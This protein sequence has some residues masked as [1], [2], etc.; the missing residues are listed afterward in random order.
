M[1]RLRDNHN[2]H[3][4][5]SQALDPAA[6]A[7]A[8]GRARVRFSLTVSMHAHQLSLGDSSRFATKAYKHYLSNTC[9]HLA[10]FLKSL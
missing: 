4:S 9:T 3:A 2:D 8:G 6:S 1:G 5:G 7:A 10:H